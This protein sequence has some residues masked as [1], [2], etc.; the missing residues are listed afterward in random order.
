M[1][2]KAHFKPVIF[3]LVVAAAGITAFHTAP[4]A[5]LINVK[6]PKD[7]KAFFHYS[8]DRIPFVSS[9]RGGPA[10]GF[11]ENCIA[12]FENTIQKT[13]SILECDPRYTKDSGVVLMHDPTLNRTST[14]SGKLNE[15]TLDEVKQMK[16]KDRQGNV[17]NYSIPTLDEVLEWAK[18]KTIMVLDQKDIPVDI[19]VKKI[20]EHKAW[21]NAI[22]IVYKLE[23]VKR[24]YELDN[25]IV[26]EVM[27]PD[28]ETAAKLEATGVPWENIVAFVTHMQPKDKDIYNYV[29]SKGALCIIGSSRTIDKDFTSGNIPEVDLPGKYRSLVSDGADIIEADLGI[30]AG[31]ALQSLMPAKSSKSIYFK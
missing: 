21:A 9:H 10:K 15:H 14:G 5:H 19:C 31:A 12:T 2:L 25:R 20:Q 23:D 8:A 1:Q 4:K 28:K 24:C 22:M 29:H 30:E 17:T 16:L 13:W 6:E 26:M 18:N 11:P 27:V 3:M 7:I